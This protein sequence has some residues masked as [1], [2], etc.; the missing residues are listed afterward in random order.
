MRKTPIYLIIGAL[1]LLFQSAYANLLLEDGFN[2]PTGSLGGAT[3]ANGP[4]TGGSANILVTSPSLTYSGLADT[5]NPGNAVTVTAAAGGY[6][7]GQFH[8]D[9]GYQRAASFIRFLLNALC[10]PT[11]ATI[12]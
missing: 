10:S 5:A 9:S 3:P 2:Y 7:Q 11:A 12:T 8:R 4:W 1:C 6:N